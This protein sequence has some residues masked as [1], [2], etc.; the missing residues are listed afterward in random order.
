[1]SWIRSLST[2]GWA[3]VAIIAL[4]LVLLATCARQNAREAAQVRRASEER[5]Q[6]L[7]QA[8]QADTQASED[9]L[10]DI[11][12]N[13][14]REKERTD[15]VS[16]LPDAPSSPV[17]RRL[18]CVWLRDQGIRDADLPADCRSDARSQATR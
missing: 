18:Y 5:S 7:E 12:V 16:T 15:A 3:V 11:Q 10:F 1:M 17:Q 4:T 2:L 8:R 14:N 13:L 6:T 9:R